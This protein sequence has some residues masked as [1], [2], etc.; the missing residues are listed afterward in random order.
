MIVLSSRSLRSYDSSASIPNNFAYNLDS[1]SYKINKFTNLQIHYLHH[2]IKFNNSKLDEELNQ[3][4]NQ[5][6]NMSNFIS[7]IPLFEEEYE[8][9]IFPYH[10]KSPLNRNI[11][12]NRYIKRNPFVLDVEWIKSNYFYPQNNA[13]RN[14]FQ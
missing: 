12:R 2:H 1:S 10:D 14:Y 6:K 5:F 9:N 11:I 4:E 13:K 3:I 7:E 8:S